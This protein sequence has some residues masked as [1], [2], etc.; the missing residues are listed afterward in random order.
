MTNACTMIAEATSISAVTT[1]NRPMPPSI[2]G[3]R[4]RREPAID[5]ANAPLAVTNAARIRNVPSTDIRKFRNLAAGAGGRRT[6]RV[7]RGA[8]RH[9][10]I[11]VEPVTAEP[12][13]QDDFRTFFERVG[14]DAGI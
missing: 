6:R 13:R 3:V 9:H 7:F 5:A 10:V 12:A 14:D 8:L 2:R 11:G 1:W 4:L